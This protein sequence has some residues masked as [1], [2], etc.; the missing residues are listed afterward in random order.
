MKNESFSS[1]ESKKG[2]KSFTY[3]QKTRAKILKALTFKEKSDES[4]NK[5][6]SMKH[7]PNSQKL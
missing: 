3:F 5:N 1:Q 2:P 7:H 4:Y 6:L